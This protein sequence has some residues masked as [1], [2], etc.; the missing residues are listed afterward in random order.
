MF[1][2]L[3]LVNLKKGHSWGQHNQFLVHFPKNKT[4]F[5]WEHNHSFKEHKH[6]LENNMVQ[7]GLFFLEWK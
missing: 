1:Q 4:M 5:P 6:F 2:I 3:S 7:N